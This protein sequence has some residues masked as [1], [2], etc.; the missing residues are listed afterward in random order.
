MKTNSSSRGAWWQRK[1]AGQ[2]YMPPIS[3]GNPS[4][5]EFLGQFG[6]K[7]QLLLPQRADVCSWAPSGP[8]P[9][10]TG[11]ETMAPF[12]THTKRLMQGW[13]RFVVELREAVK[14]IRQAV[15]WTVALR[16]ILSTLPAGQWLADSLAPQGS[17]WD[18]LLFFDA[19]LISL[20]CFGLGPL[21][22]LRCLAA[23]LVRKRPKLAT[24]HRVTSAKKTN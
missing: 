10:S 9:A 18:T 3:L 7:E 14:P 24:T 21:V 5:S 23:I 12:V 4:V 19:H 22:L 6:W 8:R 15:G 17:T 1:G 11:S 20:L 13:C 16:D 2:E